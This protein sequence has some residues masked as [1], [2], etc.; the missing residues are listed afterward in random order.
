MTLGNKLNTESST[1]S[2]R[3]NVVTITSSR[4]PSRDPGFSILSTFLLTII[5]LTT[6]LHAGYFPTPLTMVDDSDN[7]LTLKDNAAFAAGVFYEEG[8]GSSGFNSGDQSRKLGAMYSP[9]ESF[10]TMLRNP[11]GSVQTKLATLD[12][13][14]FT[15]PDFG[16]QRGAVDISGHI[17]HRQITLGGAAHLRFITAIPGFVDLAFYAPFTSKRFDALNIT[18]RQFQQVDIIDLLLEPH[19]QNIG[20]FLQN[21]GDLNTDAW[22]GSGIG[23]PTVV[24]RWNWQQTLALETISHLAT[25][26]Y[27]GCSLPV[28]KQK[29]EDQLFSLPLGNDGHWGFPFGA[30]LE[31]M[32][33]LPI[34]TGLA[35]DILYQPTESRVRRVKTDVRQTDLL[36]LNKANVQCK[37]GLTWRTHWFIE[38]VNFWRSLSLRGAYEFVMHHNDELSTTDAGFSS[39]IIS[40][41]TTAQDWY[42]HSFTATAK[43][44][45]ANEFTGAPIAPT[46]EA[47][48]KF[49]L[50]G[51][52]VVN[53]NSAGLN[54]VI[55]F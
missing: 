38:G 6:T 46:I 20:S 21:T 24:L 17:F 19:I 23:D 55:R 48:L 11:Q 16:G 41:T 31:L 30:N 22:Q 42:V 29:N 34:K 26:V 13:R 1:S 7:F 12:P 5:L 45:L 33:T 9:Q 18:R 32:F 14:L 10:L 3:S 44:D 35:A 27:V 4:P 15:A 8:S 53:A 49:P 36:L 37:P 52:R 25:Q 43:Y 54:L 40:T 47:F 2:T 39:A 28:S 50:S 51:R